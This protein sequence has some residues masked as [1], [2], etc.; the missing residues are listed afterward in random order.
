MCCDLC[1]D[2]NGNPL[3][4]DNRGKPPDPAFTGRPPAGTDANVPPPRF[5]ANQS[6]QDP[7]PTSDTPTEQIP[8]PGDPSGS[9]NVEY[10]L[11]AKAYSVSNGSFI[12]DLT[13]TIKGRYGA[14]V[15][16]FPSSTNFKVGIYH[17]IG[18]PLL[19]AKGV[20]LQLSEGGRNASGGATVRVDLVSILPK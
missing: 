1:K 4:T 17:S 20:F 16:E 10:I 15:T 9:I 14:I 19:P 5:P 8:N 3:T 13:Y 12:T 11:K 2:V 7:N 18:V 6:Y